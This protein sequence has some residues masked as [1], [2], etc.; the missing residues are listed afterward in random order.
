LEF[1]ELRIVVLLICAWSLVASSRAH[2]PPA[3]ACSLKIELIDGQ[4]HHALPGIVQVLLDDGQVVKLP[5][6]VNR[7]QGIEQ[8]GPIHDWWV[9]PKAST[10]TVP[11]APLVVKAVSGLETELAVKR[12]DLTGKTEATIEVPLVRF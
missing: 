4:S 11:A 6:L 10:V 5:E 3:A 12:I 2:E 7:G 1:A 9:L 8:H